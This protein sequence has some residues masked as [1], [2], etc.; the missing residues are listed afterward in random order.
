MRHRAR[1]GNLTELPASVPLRGGVGGAHGLLTWLLWK[2]AGARQNHVEDKN[3]SLFSPQAGERNRVWSENA[4]RKVDQKFK[5]PA[6]S[7]GRTFG[8]DL[9][10]GGSPEAGVCRRRP[11]WF[12]SSRE[13]GTLHSAQR[14]EFR[15]AVFP[16]WLPPTSLCD[17]FFTTASSG[18]EPPRTSC[19][20][21]HNKC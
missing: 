8:G 17:C 10:R 5:L 2:L 15:P 4:S 1:K 11:P 14:D 6:G 3:A 21:L 18:R 9:G 13:P 16:S 7:P 19:E 12:H 20:D